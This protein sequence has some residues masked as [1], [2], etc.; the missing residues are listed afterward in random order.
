MIEVQPALISA[1]K[2]MRNFKLKFR[3][4]SPRKRYDAT[5][6][7]GSL[8]SVMKFLLGFKPVGGGGGG[9]TPRKIG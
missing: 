4:L 2:Y 6:L 1:L 8:L 7:A 3:V 5:N 9:S